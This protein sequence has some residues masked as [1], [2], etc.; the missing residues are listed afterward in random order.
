MKYTAQHILR[1]EKQGKFPK[2]IK[3]GERRVVWRSEEIMAWREQKS[4]KGSDTVAAGI[5]KHVAKVLTFILVKLRALSNN[6][7]EKN[8]KQISFSE[9]LMCLAG[10]LRGRRSAPSRDALRGILRGDA[11]RAL[12]C[13]FAH[14]GGRPYT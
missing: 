14:A 8:L 2:R 7:G 4:R 9:A 5:S 1:L 13:A 3:V 10:G 11:K 12:D 6:S